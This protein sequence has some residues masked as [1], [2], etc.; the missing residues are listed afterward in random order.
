MVQP[1]AVLE[2]AMPFP[3]TPS[4]RAARPAVW[5]W[6]FYG[7]MMV[8]ALG[9][10][11]LTYGRLKVQDRDA[12]LHQGRSLLR[13]YSLYLSDILAAQEPLLT[14][15]CLNRL[16]GETWG[17]YAILSDP[18]GKTMVTA[19]SA[20]PAPWD[21][22]LSEIARKANDFKAVEA[23]EGANAME[24]VQPVWVASKK[25]GTLRWGVWTDSLEE[26]ARAHRARLAA[27]WGYA[28]LVGA[29]FAALFAHRCGR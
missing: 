12:F 14:Q 15:A 25:W 4:R 23:P 24:W 22:A 16:A 10:S 20:P 28:A 26:K 1:S 6:G 2:E 18:K 21:Q 27:S 8:W 7:L 9:L 5:I 13:H 19:G 11:F 29:V 3:P 17:R